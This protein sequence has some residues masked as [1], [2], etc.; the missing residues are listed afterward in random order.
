MQQFLAKQGN[1]AAHWIENAYGN[2]LGH[3]RKADD[4]QQKK[5]YE[6]LAAYSFDDWQGVVY[7]I[8]SE[9]KDAGTAAAIEAGSQILELPGTWTEAEKLARITVNSEVKTGFNV[10]NQR[11]AAY[12]RSRSAEM[13]GMKWVDGKLVENPSAQWAITDS[14]REWLRE[15]ITGAFEGKDGPTTP[16]KLA[17]KI[18][19]SSA[20]SKSRARMIAHTEVGNA[21]VST[22][23]DYAVLMGA[24]HKRTR[25]SADHPED[26]DDVCVDAAGEGEVPIDHVYAGGKLMPLFHPRC[27]CSVSTYVRRGKVPNGNEAR[28]QLAIQAR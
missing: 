22:Q 3:L 18:R 11:A 26:D 10:V 23:F 7:E 27:K 12:A 1:I 8:E 20:F 28:N 16:A 6:V 5:I 24:T 19:A 9:L 2:A 17:E 14:T 13:V 21:N 4:D 25:L 15:T